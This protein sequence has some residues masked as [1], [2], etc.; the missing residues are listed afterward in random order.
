MLEARQVAKAYGGTMALAG[1]DFRLERGR[2]HALIGENGAGKS[3]LLKILAGVEQPT[4]GTL[5][6]R[7]AR[8]R[9][10]VGRRRGRAR[11]SA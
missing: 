5:R 9:V 4:S 1:V 8:R 11:A 3:T 7:R 6:L 2:V 10:R